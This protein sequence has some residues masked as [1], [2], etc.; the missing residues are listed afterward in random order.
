M[1]WSYNFNTKWKC[2]YRKHVLFSASV[3]PLYRGMIAVH[4]KRLFK[5]DWNPPSSLS[6]ICKLVRVGT[7][8]TID[9]RE[10]TITYCFPLMAI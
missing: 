7:T 1:K 3:I 6:P 5:G 4:V 2:Q 9:S 10:M 8:H